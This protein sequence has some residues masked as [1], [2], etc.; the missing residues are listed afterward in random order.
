MVVSVDVLGSPEGDEAHLVSLTAPPTI[1]GKGAST[2]DQSGAILASTT[3]THDGAF[4]LFGD[5]NEFSN[6]S[7]R[8]GVVSIG[9]DGLTA[10]QTL[11]NIQDPVS[12]VTSPFD[13]HVLVASGYGNALF[14]LG[15]ASPG[16]FANEGAIKYKGGKPQLPADMVMIER[17]SLR[18]LVLLSEVDGVRLVRFPAAGGAAQ[19]QGL[20]AL[21]DG[22]QLETI[23]GAIGVQP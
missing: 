17:G 3:V 1:V 22:E 5:N 14:S 7:N 4:G 12:M 19:D 8:V 9:A 18:G 10:V 2:W 20:F 16:P 6:P 23:P 13:L 21:G 11:S 15:P